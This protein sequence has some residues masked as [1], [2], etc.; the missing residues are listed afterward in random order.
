MK[1]FLKITLWTLGILLL[2]AWIAPMALRGKIS[3]IV[4]EEANALLKARF[5]FE[6][7]DISLLR[8]FPNASLELRGMTLVGVERFE[9]DTIV[10][11]DRISVVVN[12]FSLLGDEGIVVK[13]VILAR[14][15][16]HGHKLSDGAVNWDVMKPSEEPESEVVVVEEPA[17]EASASSFRLALRDFR[18][19]EAELRYEDDSTHLAAS[20]SPLNLRLRGD[21]SAA[22]STLDLQLEMERLN[23]QSGV[24]KLLHEA[25]LALD[26]AV[27]A[28]LEKSHFTLSENSLRLNA[29]TL[30]LDGWAQLLPDG[31]IDMDLKAG[32][33]E[34]QFKDVLSM[35]PAFYTKEFKNLTAGGELDLS[36]WIKGRMQGAQ[37]PAFELK[38]SV[39]DG[40]FQ[41]ASLPKA[42][43]D[44]QVAA[45]VA[46]P[47]AEMDRT[48]V[49]LSQF[50]LKMAGNAVSANFYATNLMSDPYLKGAIRGEV[51]LGTIKEVY[52]LEDMTLQGT[53]TADLKAAGRISDV[54]QQRYDALQASGTMVV[55][56]MKLT[57]A[58][59]PPVALERVAATITPQAMTLGELSLQ[60]GRSDL[61]ANGQLVN[62]L[63]YLMRDAQ[64][65]GRLYVKS[66][67]L[68]L[69]ELMSAMASEEPADDASQPT[70]TP[71][72]AATTNPADAAMAV[73]IPA[74]L[75]LSL[76]TDLKQILFQ[77]M[78]IDGVQ[79]E[80]TLRDSALSLNKLNM[81]LFG[82]RATASGRYAAPAEA[83]P[84]FRV[85]L[86]LKDASF[87]Q[88]FEQLELVQKMVPIFA[89]TGGVYALSLDLT[90]ALDQTLTPIAT[91][92]NAS[93][94]LSSANIR[95]QNIGV[96]DALSK[97]VGTT[98]LTKWEAN[99]VL[100]KFAIRDGRLETKPFDVKIDDTKITF[101]GST[102]LDETI[103]YTAEVSLPEKATKG[104]LSKVD[105]QI[106][107]T[108]AKPEIR[109]DMKAAAEEAAKNIVNEQVQRLT[110]SETLS[111][112][113]AKQADTLRAR[114]ARA[115][116]KLV[117]E[118]EK[119]AAK[120][121]EEGAKKGGVA[122]IAAEAAG[123]KLVS[124]A[125]KQ[126]DKLQAAAEEQISRL[127]E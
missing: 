123:K 8:H 109:V 83:D 88:T 99:N 100:V 47:G 75:D 85:N 41:Y 12:P 10:S 53:I 98:K 86:G 110:G 106:G 37:L 87:E 103:D 22:Q 25:E 28:D 42:V 11:A 116:A 90:T 114:A 61:A 126:A 24:V 117:E 38:G 121:A 60:V 55:E 73:A 118:A 57:M 94:E 82:G 20:V 18:I 2:V 9:G 68:D 14:P 31:A 113:V 59:L 91:S 120:L 78:T 50:S 13:K 127:T 122:K 23:V 119:Q 19:R 105:V 48:E 26:A 112:E 5:D 52:P 4:K 29:I 95:L 6:L 92:V 108:F 62:Y 69:N 46:N 7:L 32:T 27:A 51:N 66:N 79:G 36:C 80:V 39:R 40:R 56:Q 16:V 107:G 43:T 74:N 125:Q 58:S 30:T 3:Q 54:E 65:S 101:S 96:L 17:S 70:A 111:E 35:I 115:G 45:R 63:G 33:R 124:E 93:G 76:A 77:K 104:K 34:V 97:A 81:G 71:Q 84:T 64:L 15:T 102:G 89:K 44:I 1:R 49:D 72:T 67:L 21:L